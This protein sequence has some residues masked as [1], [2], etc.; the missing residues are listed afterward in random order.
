M[1]AMFD[2]LK[3]A[4]SL[5]GAGFAKGQAEVLATSFAEATSASHEELVTRDYLKASLAEQKA[6]LVRWLITS[7][8]ALVVI[9]AALSNFTRI[10]Q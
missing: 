4:R 2:T 10:F 7:Q 3:M 6:D 5:E 9:L 1:Q 8:V